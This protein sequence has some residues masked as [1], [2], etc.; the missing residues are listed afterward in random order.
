MRSIRAG[1]L[2]VALGTLASRAGA[3][4]V[5][6]RPAAPRTPQASPPAPLP[7]PILVVEVAGADEEPVWRPAAVHPAAYRP[8]PGTLPPRT[9]RAQAADVVSLPGM[10]LPPRVP[11]FVVVGE[12]PPAKI[13]DMAPPKDV[14]IAPPPTKVDG[15][16]TPAPAAAPG[17]PGDPPPCAPFV[18]T[19]PIKKIDFGSPEMRIV[20]E[21]PLGLDLLP[22]RLVARSW[23]RAEYLLWW[24]KDDH[25][26]PLAT[27]G[28]P[29]SL[30]FLGRPGTVPLFGPGSFGNSL[31]NGARLSGGL[32]LDDC[33]NCGID[34]SIFWLG[35]RH[36]GQ[37]F[38]S[39]QFPVLARPVFAP[40]IPGEFAEIVG[41]PGLSTGVLAINGSSSLWGADLNA[42]ETLCCYCGVRAD[43]F[44]GFRYL[45]LSEDINITEYIVAGPN[46]PDPAGTAIVVNDS[47]KTR[48]QFYGGQ[49]G[50]RLDRTWGRFFGFMSASVA[51]GDTHQTLDIN[52][53]QLKTLPG[54]PT[55]V[56]AGGLLTTP[57]TNIGHFT[58]DRFSVVPQL[59]M[60][61]GYQV[62]NNLRVFAGYNFLYWT[63]VIRP[64]DQIDR[65]VD[66]ALVPNPPV[67]VRPTGTGHPAVLFKET[68]F[69]A[70]GLNLGFEVRW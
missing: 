66:V 44:A 38:D 21:D 35:K 24:V 32:W 64:G 59:T 63:N 1:L 29:D 41:A 45:D 42:F 6:W 9:V 46:A 18:P 28:T 19:P 62:T 11:T 33:M 23:F 60:N 40:N 3:E 16:L 25:I 4:D 31:R 20:K 56:F 5:I 70:Q 48:N 2:V 13:P 10:P 43:V 52:G 26:P 36:F 67:G 54:Q 12:E 68:D 39:N 15:G 55:Q 51:L 57:T 14:E 7:D 37:V 50:L 30:G 69:W 61:F 22:S 53:F 17:L 47:F 49:L 8:D 58:R 34:G 65:V 27:A